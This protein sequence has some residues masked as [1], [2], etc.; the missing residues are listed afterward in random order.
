MFAAVTGL[1]QSLSTYGT[2][3]LIEMPTADV[4]N[5]GELALTASGFG[6]NKRYQLAFQALPQVY[7]AFRYSV[8]DDFNAPNNTDC[9]D[10]SF[11]IHFQLADETPTRPAVAFGLRDFLG[12]GIYSSEY[13]VATKSVDPRL[14]LTA[15]VGWGRLGGV[16]EIENPLGRLNA[17]FKTRPER[18][19][20]TGKVKAGNWL[21]GPMAFFGGVEWKATPHTSL[22]FEHSSD[23]YDEET[24]KPIS[25]SHLR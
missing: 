13:L 3:G 4:L 17:R 5:D 14:R 7:G 6:P 12:T 23:A 21:R 19:G 25:T 20:D 10:R 16:G 11:D 18:G 15:G 1:A 24:E 8:I 2:P 22:Y 9:Y